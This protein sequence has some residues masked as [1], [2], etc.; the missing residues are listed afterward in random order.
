MYIVFKICEKKTLFPID[1]ATLDRNESSY[2]SREDDSDIDEH[3]AISTSKASCSTRLMKKENI[4]AVN[5]ASPKNNKRVLQSSNDN[6]LPIKPKK[7]CNCN[8]MLF[9]LQIDKIKPNIEQQK[10]LHEQRM[11]TAEA[12]TKLVILWVLAAEEE[13]NNKNKV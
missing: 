4:G 13:F 11:K 8:N 1:T 9:E 7:K 3:E 6:A 2:S 12:E 5:K 10:E